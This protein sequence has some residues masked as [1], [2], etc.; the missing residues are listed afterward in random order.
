MKNLTF[1]LLQML[2]DFVFS[3][4]KAPNEFVISSNFP[5]KTYHLDRDSM[6]TLQDVGLTSSAA[7]F[8]Q[9]IS[10]DSSDDEE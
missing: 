6:V 2:Y 9:D 7:L 1:L 5:R 4:D 8:V 3:H 10:E